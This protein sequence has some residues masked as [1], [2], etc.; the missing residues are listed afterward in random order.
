MVIAYVSLI[1]QRKTRGTSESKATPSYQDI[2]PAKMLDG[3]V[4]QFLSDL[5]IGDVASD[6]M[7]LS[8]NRCS[9]HKFGKD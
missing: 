2:Q 7:N 3:F 5:V 4:D 1:N 9:L 8:E 6:Y